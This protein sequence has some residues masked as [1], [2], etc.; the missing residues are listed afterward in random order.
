MYYE[1]NVAH[2]GKSL[3]ATH[4]RSAITLQQANIL[5]E[6]IARRFPKAEGYEVTMVRYDLVGTPIY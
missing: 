6:E 5:Y 1:I 4:E 2:H 3:F